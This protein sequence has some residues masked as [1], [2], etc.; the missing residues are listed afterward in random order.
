MGQNVKRLRLNAESSKKIHSWFGTKESI[1][2][3][4]NILLNMSQNQSRLFIET[5]LKAE[6]FENC[7]IATSDPEVLDGLQQILVNAGYGSTV[8]TR[9][10][11]IGKKLIFVLRIIKHKDSY[12]Q[13]IKKVNYSGVIWC[14]NTANET[15]I[16]RRNGKVFITGNT[17]FTNVTMD[18]KVPSYMKDEPVIVGGIP[19]KETYKDFQEEMDLFN[20]AFA[21]VMIEGD[22]SGRVFTFPIPTYNITKDFEWDNP[23]YELIWEMTAKYGIPY[24][25]NFVNSD[26]KPEDA[27]SMCPLAGDEKV[28]IKSSRGR[29]LEF[30]EIR[31][32]FKSASKNE[33]YEIF[34][35]GKF[36]KG[37]FNRFENQEMIKIILSNGHEI[38]M[39]KEHLNFVCDKN[40]ETIVKGKELN[41]N[42][43]LP[44]SLNQLEGSGGNKELGFFVGA[45]AGDGSFDGETSVIF[46]LE[47]NFKK[48][49]IQKLKKIGENYFGAHSS[50][51]E[52]K[53]T[54]LVTLK[55]HS[56]AAVGLC[57]DFVDDKQR[58][59]HYN[60]RLFDMSKEFRAGV[61]EGHYET[62]GGNKNRIY[63]SSKKMVQSLNMLSATLGTTTSVFTDDRKE[64]F[65]EEPN[66]SVLIYQLNRESYGDFW[67]KK[68]GKLWIK[69]KEILPIK[70]DTAYCFEVET[71][72]PIF[73]V[74]SGILTHNCRLRLDQTELRKRGGG[75]FGANPQT[76]SIGVVTINMPRLGFTS[77]DE[78]DFFRKLEYLMELSKES[79]EIKRK[80]IEK[81]TEVG[82]YPY[83]K[84]YLRH[85]KERFN[86]YWK[87]HFATIGL[88]GMNEAITNFMQGETIATPKGREFATK[89]LDFMRKKLEE[90]QKETGNIYN[91]EATP[92][93]GTT[94]RFARM[95]KT[96]FGRIQVANEP[97]VKLGAKPYYTNSTQLPVKYT[98]DIFEALNLQDELQCKY[99]GGTVFHG[100]VGEKINPE[101]VKILIKKIS[102]KYHLPYFTITP[103]FSICPIHGY[104]SG[105]HDFCPKCDDEIAH[106]KEMTK[107][108]ANE[109][110]N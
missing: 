4:P 60:A 6:G 5:Y 39:S 90:Y 51:I 20:K 9:K 106:E 19:Q 34:S 110:K 8:L 18:L 45:Y 16:A 21:E 28:L 55:I 23:N 14:P 82:L 1:K 64:R 3:I 46:S 35:D 62:D 80:S 85:V 73:T 98:Q 84:F 107:G 87:N 54:R 78:N 59:K 37:K 40:N 81:L 92:G 65:G 75:L 72:T 42:L 71:G 25:S 109:T 63:T 50:I 97:A 49:L 105:E 69:I 68:N 43:Y 74:G 44:Y 11:T 31:N 93:E 99:T 77:I 57:K 104:I 101:M 36:I 86:H 100:F 22:A 47:N 33:Q 29:G 89:V 41:T 27:R 48:E 79:L 17:P 95:D 91:L 83:S 61:L 66:Y 88:L 13:Q 103:T 32:I 30:G 52:D 2:F 38:K 10:P 26:M 76:G 58:E 56:K 96:K 53:K 15:V 24:F 102:D 12:I 67:F 70:N 108:G 94:Y 7:K